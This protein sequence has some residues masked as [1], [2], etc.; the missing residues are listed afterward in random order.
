MLDA[1][2]QRFD[3]K[4]ELSEKYPLLRGF[5]DLFFAAFMK[6]LVEKKEKK[7][8]IIIWKVYYFYYLNFETKKIFFV[9]IFLQ[10]HN[11]YSQN[12]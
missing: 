9:F 10:I 4:R 3:Q 12:F 11:N 1:I 6:F 8:E 7:L 5:Y 2:K